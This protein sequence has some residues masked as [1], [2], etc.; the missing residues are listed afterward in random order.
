M[1][2]LWSTQDY[3]DECRETARDPVKLAELADDR[4]CEPVYCEPNEIQV[5]L[6]TEDLAPFRSRLRLLKE[7]GLLDESAQAYVWRS[8]SGNWHASVVLDEPLD[9]KRRIFLALCLGSDEIREILNL[10]EQREAAGTIVLFR[11]KGA[12]IRKVTLS[13]KDEG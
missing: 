6:D 2:K 10:V 7:Q 12:I 4:S 3:F 11:P 9:V 5:D 8:K 13:S 1:R